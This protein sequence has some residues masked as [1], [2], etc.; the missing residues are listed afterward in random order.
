MKKKKK[1]VRDQCDSVMLLKTM[2]NKG[3]KGYKRYEGIKGIKASTKSFFSR[4]Y[5]IEVLLFSWLD[6][7]K[8]VNAVFEIMFKSMFV[9]VNL[10]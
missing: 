3:I 5:F 7:I 2:A 10:A 8:W 1:S 4:I 6:C 9:K